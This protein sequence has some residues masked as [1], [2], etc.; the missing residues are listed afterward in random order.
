V[1]VDVSGVDMTHF[2][3]R[4]KSEGNLGLHKGNDGVLRPPT[5]VG[6]RKAHAKKC[7]PLEE[8]IQ[9][10]ND[11]FGDVLS[12]ERK[13]KFAD[14]ARNIM[15]ANETL[16]SQILN[17]SFEQVMSAGETK[18][19]GERVL[20]EAQEACCGGESSTECCAW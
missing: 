12:D 19:F 15:I 7:G 11:V 5:F 9:A 20:V 2:R 1:L 17:N 6:S 16:K 13:A 18:E 14:T 8:V 3:A 4:K 10:V